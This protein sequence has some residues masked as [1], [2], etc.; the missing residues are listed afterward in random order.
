MGIN[1][2][3]KTGI[4]RLNFVCKL[5]KQMVFK[6]NQKTNTAWWLKSWVL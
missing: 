2:E 1:N 3:E 6:D 4:N 5:V